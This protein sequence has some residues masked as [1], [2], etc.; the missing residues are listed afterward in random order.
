MNVEVFLCML[1][2]M[3]EIEMSNSSEIQDGICINFMAIKYAPYFKRE[4]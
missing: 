4:N 1:S 2:K 3:Y